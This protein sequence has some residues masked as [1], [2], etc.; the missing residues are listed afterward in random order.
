[1]KKYAVYKPR[2]L[3]AAT[4]LFFLFQACVHA[5]PKKGAPCNRNPS[6][7]QQALLDLSR[8]YRS[9]SGNVKVWVET[10]EGKFS[11]SGDLYARSPDKLH[12]DIFGF[13]HRP[14]FLLIKNGG[15]IAWKDFESGRHYT[16]PLDKCPPFPIK[17]PFSPLFL[18]DFMRIL[19]LNFP[20][21]IKVL[22][23][24]Q[25]GNP[26][27]FFLTCGWGKFDMILNPIRNLP[28]Q[29]VGPEGSRTPF[30]LTFSKYSGEGDLMVPHRYIIA[31]EKVKMEVTFKSLEVNP[32]IPDESFTPCCGDVHKL[33]NNS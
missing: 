25:P 29:I 16:G 17:F 15:F 9:L 31:V 19:F 28:S 3:G 27:R 8:T 30:R 32:K 10:P 6:V 5:P 21:P 7:Y 18:R 1:M 2:S 23:A 22:P 12:F 24:R 26:C 13:L 14:R 33:I 4:L 11:L 20:S